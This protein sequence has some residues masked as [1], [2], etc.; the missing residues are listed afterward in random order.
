MQE[1]ERVFR[2]RAMT[3]ASTA[4]AVVLSLPAG[5]RAAD[6]SREQLEF[7]EKK[8][9]PVMVPHCYKCNAAQAAKVKG[10]LRLDSRDG[11]LKGGDSGPALVPG[12]PAASLLLKA[13]RY[14]DVK[15]P[16]TG[17]LP[18]AVIADFQTWIQQ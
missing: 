11:L 2:A 18:D 14:G 12:N 3:V 1:C 15:M 7:F 16:P 10:G 17:K 9:R 8:I 4:L 6:P 5:L 13:L